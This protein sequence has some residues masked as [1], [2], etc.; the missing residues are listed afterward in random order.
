L[1]GSAFATLLDNEP[2]I[3]YSPWFPVLSTLSLEAE[4]AAV[5]ALAYLIAGYPD[6]LVERRWQRIALRCAWVGLLGPPLGLLAS[7][8]VPVSSWAPFGIVVSNPYALRGCPG[9]AEPAYGS[10]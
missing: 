8:V 9:R 1:A 3:I 7:P 2:W 10:P 4:A 5:L 6:G